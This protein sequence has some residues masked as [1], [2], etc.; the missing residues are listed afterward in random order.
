[1][2]VKIAK[3]S[4][5]GFYDL[6]SEIIEVKDW[7]ELMEILFKKYPRWILSKNPFEDVDCDALMY[8]DYVE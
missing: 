6:N 8:D 7:N 4:E 3:A 2:K 1:V 5:G